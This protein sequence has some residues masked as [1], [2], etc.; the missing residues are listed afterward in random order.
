M[1]NP[2][3]YF[4]TSVG[5]DIDFVRAEKR[6]GKGVVGIYCEFTPRDLILAAGAYP[7]CLCGSSRKT[8]P[9]A[10]TVLPANLCPLIK[11]SIGYILTN[12]CP[13]FSMAD[14]IVAEM[15]CDGKKKVW[16]IISDRKPQHILELTQKVQE[17]EAWDHWLREVEKLKLRLEE[18]YGR[19][20]TDDDLR[21][22]ISRMHSERALLREIMEYGAEPRPV[23]SGVELGRLRYRVSGMPGH[24]SMLSELREALEERKRKGVFA[25][26]ENA[27]RVLVTGCPMSEGTLKI[28]E[29]IEESGGIVVVQETCSGIKPLDPVSGE[30]D[31]LTAIAEKHFRI[32]CSCMTPNTGRL[33]LLSKL[34]T[35]YRADAVVDLVWQA[36]HTYNVESFRVGDFVRRELGLPYLKVETDYSPGDR[37]QIMVRIQTLLEMA[38]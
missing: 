7:I 19:T 31:P 24:Q 6:R 13:F 23:I 32:P 1:I 33:E 9:P 18:L 37:E 34:A 21:G 29:I 26:R 10:E 30:G 36:C 5:A 14:L 20:I 28:V 38:R 27:P 25:A 4:A 12:G 15:T 35:Q 8:I 22:A 3:E 16:E 17:T 2:F 11:S